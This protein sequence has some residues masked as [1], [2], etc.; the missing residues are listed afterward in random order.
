M[1]CRPTVLHAYVSPILVLG[2]VGGGCG[3]GYAFASACTAGC[4]AHSNQIRYLDQ[5]LDSLFCARK[6][7]LDLGLLAL[8]K[9]HH[10]PTES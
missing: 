8:F 3:L 7:Y 5:R 4:L 10:Y 9:R 1:A 2:G 6:V